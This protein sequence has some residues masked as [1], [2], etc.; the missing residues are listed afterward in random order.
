MHKKPVTAGREITPENFG[1]IILKRGR[2]SGGEKF[3]G[4]KSAG[5]ED[6]PA[7]ARRSA[8]ELRRFDK[9]A[10]CRLEKSDHQPKRQIAK[11]QQS[12]LSAVLGHVRAGFWPRAF[13]S[14]AG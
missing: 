10:Q 3:F 11:L 2:K 8:N 6:A 12:F 1:P 14:C 4:L 9:R 13:F 7:R 5:G